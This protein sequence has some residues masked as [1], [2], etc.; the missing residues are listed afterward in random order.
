MRDEPLVEEE[1]QSTESVSPGA[2]ATEELLES[3]TVEEQIDAVLAL[4]ERTDE[5]DEEGML[6][7]SEKAIAAKRAYERMTREDNL[8]SMQTRSTSF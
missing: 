5:L 8:R 2:D 4:L 1:R 3:S 6:S 7:L